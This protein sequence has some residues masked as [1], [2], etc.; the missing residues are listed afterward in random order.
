MGTLFKIDLIIIIIKYRHHHKTLLWKSRDYLGLKFL[1]LCDS[2]LKKI[3]R[4]S[5]LCLCRRNLKKDNSE[6]SFYPKKYTFIA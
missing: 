2:I 5:K 3:V 4:L 6:I 1:F